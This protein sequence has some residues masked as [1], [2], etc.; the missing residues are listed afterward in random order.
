MTASTSSVAA[1]PVQ[2]PS[3]RR[4]SLLPHQNDS[5]DE[6]EYARFMRSIMNG[7]DA[8]IMTFRTLASATANNN[9]E[10]ETSNGANHVP[11]AD[12]GAGPN[13]GTIIGDNDMIGSALDDL[14]DDSYHLTS[15]EEEDD[16]DD[17]ED[18]DDDNEHD[19]DIDENDDGPKGKDHAQ[20]QSQP[21]EREIEGE[22]KKESDISP[23]KGPSSESNKHKPSSAGKVDEEY[24]SPDKQSKKGTPLPPTPMSGSSTII[25]REG[26]G[27]DLD[28][29]N[30]FGEIEGLM[31][32]DLEAAVTTLLQSEPLNSSPLGE[33]SFPHWQ[34]GS[35]SGAA[36][37]GVN[38]KLNM[39][40]ASTPETVGIGQAPYV[41]TQQ[42]K[43][44]TTPGLSTKKKK[45]TTTVVTTPSPGLSSP[46]ASNL[47]HGSASQPRGSAIPTGP[48]ITGHQ[49]R[50][51][52]KTMARHHQLLLQQAT[53]AVRAAY[54]QK[55]QKDGSVSQSSH[56]TREP[57]SKRQKTAS[58]SENS[59]PPSR[60]NSRSLTFCTPE[61]KCTY[62]NDFF[63][64]ENADEL[65]EVLDGAV[66]MLQD[67][68][69][70][71]KDAVRNSIQL[72]FASN[73]G[74][75]CGA[76]AAGPASRRKLL[77]TVNEKGIYA[78]D[79]KMTSRENN[80]D[81]STNDLIMDR[82]LTRS[83]FTK[84]LR[85]REMEMLSQ[86][87]AAAAAGK[88]SYMDPIGNV[89]QRVSA[90]DVRGLG[91]L[92]ETFAAIDNSV[93]D[94]QMGKTSPGKNSGVVNILFPQDHGEAC[95]LLLRLAGA[96]IDVMCIPGR[97]DLG[98]HLTYPPEAFDFPGNVK[99]YLTKAQQLELKKNRN[100]FTAGEDNLILRGVNLYG[101]KEWVLISDR[102]LPDR[103]VNAISQRY[104]R[105]CFLIYKA[106]GIRIDDQ[107]KLGLIPVHDKG[108]ETFDEEAIS[109]IKRATPPTTMNV[110]RWTLEEDITLL[111]AVP[112]MGNM[113][114]EICNRLMPHRDRGHIRKR[115]QVLERRIPK[116]VTKMNI[117]HSSLKRNAD[118]LKVPMATAK[119]ARILPPKS[120]ILSST[121]FPPMLVPA[122]QH[123]LNPVLTKQTAF[124]PPG[125]NLIAPKSLAAKTSGSKST[126]TK[127]S[128]KSIASAATKP[129]TKKPI[130]K[131]P[132]TKKLPVK[133]PPAKKPTAK[134]ANTSE[135]KARAKKSDQS[136]TKTST[137][138]SE[139][140]KNTTKN[141]ASKNNHLSTTKST[142][143]DEKKASAP[144]KE[145]K[146]ST[147]AQETKTPPK[148]SLRP[149]PSTPENFRTF[150]GTNTALHAALRTEG[151]YE[152]GRI[153]N[154]SPETRTLAALL[155]GFSSAS[156]LQFA[157]EQELYQAG[158]N[159]QMGVEKILQNGDSWSQASRMERLLQIGAAESNF[160]RE[161]VE[162]ENEAGQS[163]Q[164][165]F[166]G[167]N[168]LPMLNV[169]DA[170]ASGLS[171][172]NEYTAK[173]NQP[174]Q[175]VIAHASG[176]KKSILSSVLE[177]A[178]K[179]KENARKRKAQEVLP[180]TPT[181]KEE[182]QNAESPAREHVFADGFAPSSHPTSAI[183]YT[184]GT[185]GPVYNLGTPGPDSLNL[186]K[187][188][189]SVGEEFFEYFMTDKSRQT[190]DV[191][192][193]KPK[194]PS[195]T[196]PDSPSKFALSPARF[197][198]TSSRFASS[199]AKFEIH[200][201]TPL[202]QLQYFGGL[203]GG[204]SA[205]LTAGL[206]GPIDG[207]N[208]LLMGASD[209]DAVSALKDLSNS[210][211][212]T[213]SKFLLKPR[214]S[215]KEADP[216]HH[217]NQTHERERGAEEMKKKKPISLF[218]KIKANLKEKD[219]K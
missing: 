119:H 39:N 160:V 38:A 214:D 158:E 187:S 94:A 73:N 184:L 120:N 60:L 33:S 48:V 74:N 118:H 58:T 82:R 10:K 171:I 132:V 50:S 35:T 22:E 53:L 208:S 110:H 104:N 183:S 16:E 20:P 189:L 40:S 26:T 45:S 161:M 156:H 196:E 166:H 14:D 77:P 180:G 64:G 52:R 188:Q 125:V 109:K 218:A 1:P 147:P 143:S 170:E 51:L 164:R 182:D 34:S 103:V 129:A 177:N 27:E 84:T 141:A 4:S 142:Q 55:V 204:L 165:S 28:N 101:E 199:P 190:A 126:A 7:D 152:S 113:W 153:T 117:K 102:F 2:R 176:G 122:Y 106:H 63:S 65:A 68:E 217:D 209:F 175:P 146:A 198:N 148:V 128:N 15:E 163:K 159:T 186:T 32:E 69:Q 96:E 169:D 137:P 90:F 134:K 197:S 86:A 99:S 149:K 144:S 11:L 212:P 47:S 23:K 203:S 174:S 12:G 135:K 85:E 157:R 133:N 124:H 8:S 31:E 13:L 66:G 150:S 206:S 207:C 72:S 192:K 193:T 115:Y 112:L 6:D 151:G 24:I 205:G 57:S 167:A 95:E 78:E 202:T 25:S 91:R 185:P 145:T 59:L 200:P 168:N 162:S 111:R 81:E 5:D 3:N 136:K 201:N 179:I 76:P 173:T 172:I 100:Q 62:E 194:S 83:A 155:E 56:S 195:K 21:R 70:N 75:A 44:I 19:V 97:V 98:K 215:S 67:L 9:V 18:G 30:V 61:Q 88:S 54:V 116:G 108:A 71:W 89:R 17:D 29:L 191:L 79:S 211:P 213:P 107:G 131:K 92:R 42:Q 114:A 41:G 49:L 216:S 105:L 181:E 138:T 154:P 123:V 139:P 121:P 178:E 80:N 46:G 87:A 127:Q 140:A 43:A 130:A 93:K 37:H 36:G 219:A 210:A